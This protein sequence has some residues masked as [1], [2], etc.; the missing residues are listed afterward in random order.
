MSEIPADSTKEEN[1]ISHRIGLFVSL[2]ELSIRKRLRLVTC[3]SDDNHSY[4]LME[5]PTL[6]HVE[7]DA[8]IDACKASFGRDRK[9]MNA[10]IHHI[11]QSR[12]EYEVRHEHHRTESAVSHGLREIAHMV[13]NLLLRKEAEKTKVSD[14]ETVSQIAVYHTLETLVRT[15]NLESYEPERV[16]ALS[17]QSMESGKMKRILAIQV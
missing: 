17:A 4:R 3:L 1:D 10:L 13:L 16:A 7:I 12:N 5:N 6:P 11:V 14:R 8:I 2:A 9:E 15:A